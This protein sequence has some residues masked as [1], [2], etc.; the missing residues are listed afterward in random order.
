MNGEKK[1]ISKM[2][3]NPEVTMRLGKIRVTDDIVY[4]EPKLAKLIMSRIV[5]LRCE[6]FAGTFQFEY[7]AY[8]EE[9]DPWEYGDTVPEYSGE[10]K[11]YEDGR[12]ELTFKKIVI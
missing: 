3:N 8:S 12:L 7:I 10:F 9:F 11:K 4:R 6:H 2:F 1:P 5:V